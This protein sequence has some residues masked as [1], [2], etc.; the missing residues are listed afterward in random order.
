MESKWQNKAEELLKENDNHEIFSPTYKDIAI[1]AM[2]KLAEEV[3]YATNE[4][5]LNSM[6]D[7]IYTKEQVEAL[8]AKQRE[9]CA[10]ASRVEFIV[11]KKVAEYRQQCIL[12]AKLNID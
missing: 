5:W 10:E 12:N 9:L 7:G 2:C 3:E 6:K 8:L 11:D 4:R 1:K